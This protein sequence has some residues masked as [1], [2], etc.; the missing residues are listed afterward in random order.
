MVLVRVFSPKAKKNIFS[1]RVSYTHVWENISLL[2]LA[3]IWR[4]RCKIGSQQ[5]CIAH[6]WCLKVFRLLGVYLSYM[7]KQTWCGW[8]ILQIQTM[9]SHLSQLLLNYI[10]EY[11]DI[12]NRCKLF[13]K[14][15]SYNFYLAFP[16]WQQFWWPI[17]FHNIWLVAKFRFFQLNLRTSSCAGPDG[18]YISP[19]NWL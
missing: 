11:F 13:T 18:K 2:G 12:P 1:A 9:M 17:H 5:G 6:A 14:C 15:W 7:N 19:K 3:G 10:D 16:D 8:A 4:A